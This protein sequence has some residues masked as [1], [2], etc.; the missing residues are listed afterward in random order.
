MIIR[1]FIILRKI[2]EIYR[3]RISKITLLYEGFVISDLFIMRFHCICT[4][5]LYTVCWRDSSDWNFN[6]VKVHFDWFSTDCVKMNF[7]TLIQFIW[8]I[9]FP[10]ISHKSINSYNFSEPTSYEETRGGIMVRSLVGLQE[11]ELIRTWSY[12]DM[13][14]RSLVQRSWLPLGLCLAQAGLSLSTRPRL[15]LLAAMCTDP[16]EPTGT[17]TY[18]DLG[19]KVTERDIKQ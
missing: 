1:F 12:L 10:Q 11:F 17:W 4:Q 15:S 9:Y 18:K 2:K 13:F 8:L 7:N 19:E 3:A 16:Q 6:C 5:S 14:H